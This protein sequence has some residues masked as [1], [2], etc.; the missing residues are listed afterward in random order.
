MGTE[1]AHAVRFVDHEP[2]ARLVAE[3]GDRG[4]VGDVALHR[5]HAV[6]DDEH[7]AAVGGGLVE[8]ALELVQPPVAERP[9]LRAREEAAVEDRGVVA[10]VGHDG[11]ARPQQRAEGADV[12]L[13]AGGED[14]RRLG[15][16]PAGDLGLELEVQVERAI[17]EAR[18]GQAGAVAV[19]GVARTRDDPLVFGQPEVVVASEHDPLG[20]LHDDDGP[21]RRLERAEVGDDVGLAGRLVVPSLCEDVDAGGH[22]A[23]G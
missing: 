20:A 4:Q 18:A 16:V 3:V 1:H 7:A 11:V 8:L 9:Q 22:L 14:Q 19:E 21:R 5:E 12:G 6:D 23:I 2:G 10:R 13:V 17:E 15:P